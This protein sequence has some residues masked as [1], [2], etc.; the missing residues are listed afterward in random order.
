MKF[1][2]FSSLS[3]TPPILPFFLVICLNPR[4]GKGKVLKGRSV[5]RLCNSEEKLHKEGDRHCHPERKREKK[6]I[7]KR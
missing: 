6:N 1:Y 7:K 3:P 2:N 4:R 5:K